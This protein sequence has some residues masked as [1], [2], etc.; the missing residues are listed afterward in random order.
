MNNSRNKYINPL[1][2]WSSIVVTLT[3]ILYGTSMGI[4]ISNYSIPK[5]F[6]LA[7]FISK[8]DGKFI[9]LYSFCQLFAFIS[10]L[11]FIVILNCI[12]ESVEHYNKIFTR[13]SIYF[14]LAFSIL[15]SLNYFVQFSIVR[16]SINDG[17]TQNLDNFVQFNPRSFTF[18]INML[19]WS[20]FLGL[21]TLFLGIIF[22]GKG[23]NLAIRSSLYATSIF[24]L[25]GFI[26]FI[27]DIKFFLLIFQVGMSL[28]LTLSSIF[29]ALAFRKSKIE[30]AVREKNLVN[31]I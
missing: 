20:L 12:H 7:Q 22:K 14:G 23:M 27:L 21:S 28:G 24:C 15:A 8:V 16:I 5:F 30:Y 26:G 10:T 9:D 6:D 31:I 11:F 19:G 17:I 18:A 13:L 25:I 2:F 1:G 4:L 29:I 3:G